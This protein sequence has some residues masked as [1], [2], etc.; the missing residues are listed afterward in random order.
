LDHFSCA[1]A[2]TSP[3]PADELTS[4]LALPHHGLLAAQRQ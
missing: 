3:I 1:L 2:L 4:L